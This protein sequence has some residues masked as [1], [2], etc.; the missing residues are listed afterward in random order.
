VLEYKDEKGRSKFDL[1]VYA[2][3]KFTGGLGDEDEIDRNNQ[4]WKKYF[5][6]DLKQTKRIVAMQKA[7]GE[8]AHMSCRFLNGQFLI[9]AGSK[10]VHLLFKNKS[11]E[12][13]TV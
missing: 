7:N 3:R 12:K 9:A 2:L 8:A 11:I 1:I 6:K 5:L 13:L 4:D 10:N